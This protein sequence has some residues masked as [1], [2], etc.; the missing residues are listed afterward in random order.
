MSQSPEPQ[1][2]TAPETKPVYHQASSG[3]TASDP[4]PIEEWEKKLVGK[5]LIGA[6]EP[7]DENVES[8]ERLPCCSH[9]SFLIS[10]G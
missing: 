9:H 1:K 2:Y 3:D 4:A 7:G 10:F 6:N 8:I 5:R